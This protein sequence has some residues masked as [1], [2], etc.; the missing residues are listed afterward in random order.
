MARYLDETSLIEATKSK[1]RNIKVKV[2]IDWFGD[3]QFDE[4]ESADDEFL[5]LNIDKE[6]EGDLGISV[7]D[8][9]TLVLDNSN[10]DYSPKN[11]ASRF[12]VE[13]S[14]DTWEFNVIPNRFC[15]I[16]VSING[17]DYFPYFSGIITNISPQYGNSKVSLT[18]DDQLSL[19][20]NYTCDDKLYYREPAKEVI[21]DL[22]EDTQIIYSDENVDAIT[23]E[24][25][26]RITKNFGNNTSIFNAI[27]EISQ[28]AWGKF[29]IINNEFHFV[30]FSSYDVA[31]ESVVEE[32][33]ESEILSID[34]E[35]N[36]KELYNEVSFKANPLRRQG[37]TDNKHIIWSGPEGSEE[38][39][40]TYL[41]SDIATDDWLQLV[42]DEDNP[43]QNV[44]IVEGEVTV[45]FFEKEYILGEGLDDIDEENGKIKFTNNEEYPK[46]D[47]N[48]EFEVNYAYYILILQP[49]QEKTFYA[50]LEHPSINIE[51]VNKYLKVQATDLS[52]DEKYETGDESIN[53]DDINIQGDFS[54][55]TQVEYSD[56][57]TLPSDAE[58]IT[59]NFGYYKDWAHSEW[60]IL[61]FKFK[62]KVTRETKIELLVFDSSDNITNEYVL[63]SG[64]SE[65]KRKIKCDTESL[66]SDDEKIQLKV[67]HINSSSSDNSGLDLENIK[68]NVFT[69]KTDDD[70]NRIN[71]IDVSQNVYSN[72]ERVEL[73]FKNNSDNEVRIFSEYNGQEHDVLILTG[74]PLV[75]TRK[76]NINEIDDEAKKEFPLINQKLEIENNLYQEE[77]DIKRIA[78]FLLYNYSTP[79]TKLD[80]QIKGLI[81]LELLDKIKVNREESDID[82]EFLVWGIED[83][84]DDNG[85]W[86]QNLNLK[87]AETSEWIYDEEG[88]SSIIDNPNTTPSEVSDNPDNVE[89]LS[90]GIVPINTDNSAYPAI[91]V[92]YEMNDSDIRLVNV[93]YRKVGDSEWKLF[94]R[95]REEISIIDEITSSGNY[96]VAVLSENYEGMSGDI[97][98][99]PNDTIEYLADSLN[100][101]NF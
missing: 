51:S 66:Y 79:K 47:D 59:L 39:T 21:K 61:P 10:G 2:Q 48:T 74:N 42:D 49:N 75:Q 87:Q 38:I 27:Q 78:D 43:T 97:D 82:N 67:S 84:F 13:T 36:S 86:E 62:E 88:L 100:I 99:S 93:Y 24:K 14:E 95:T 68:A 40:E 23:E 20:Q 9:G 34:E 15:L 72:H 16:S 80:I 29:Y 71:N 96:E 28:L 31:N 11:I 90:L 1:R 101:N 26:I 54:G 52:T 32:I 7:R 6:A 76:F 46:P 98:N 56:K 77:D 50:D 8:Q 83:N 33:S 91:E 22:L 89:N 12:N 64:D 55:S 85:N 69:K 94:E 92:T 81:H 65:N 3:G 5:K 35:F 60:Y 4:I 19:L 17:S 63:Y 73:I 70:G 18:I 41:G 58:E 25:T 37:T 45:T 57:K 44:P 53:F 30:D